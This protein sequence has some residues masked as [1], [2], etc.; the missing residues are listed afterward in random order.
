MAAA[1]DAHSG[2]SAHTVYGGH[3][4]TLRQTLIALTAGSRLDDHESPGEATMQV[5]HGRVR[6]TSP[7]T[8]W[9]GRPG[10][11]LVIPSTRH[12]LHAVDDCVVLL[13]VAKSVQR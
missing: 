6:L 11:H 8:S 3:Q 9:D 4:H 7:D 12:C 1:H 13:T 5:L 2:R 10:D